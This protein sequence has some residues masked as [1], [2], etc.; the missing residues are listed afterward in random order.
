MELNSISVMSSLNSDNL[1]IKSNNTELHALSGTYSSY[2]SPLL[3][4]TGMPVAVMV[5]ISTREYDNSVLQN[6]STSKRSTR[7]IPHITKF[8]EHE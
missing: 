3:R 7:L 5:L 6:V 2:S 4:R 8:F 1:I